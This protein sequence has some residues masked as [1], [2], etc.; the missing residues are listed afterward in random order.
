MKEKKRYMMILSRL[1]LT[2][3][4]VVISWQATVRSGVNL[5]VE[6]GDKLLHFLAF[7]VLAVL[8]DFAFPKSRFG[9]FKIIPLIL[10]GLAIEYVQSFLPSRSASLA[11]LL[12]D[13][14]GI[15]SYLVSIPM[16]QRLPLL[17]ARWAV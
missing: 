16:L 6:N 3:A 7:A 11:D 13:I 17:Q 4:V 12:V 14:V 15:G 9:V 10:Y 1:M 5:H 2:A 8:V